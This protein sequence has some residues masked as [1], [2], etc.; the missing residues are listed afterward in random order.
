MDPEQVEVLRRGEELLARA[1]AVART[2][3]RRAWNL[4]QK[5]RPAARHSRDGTAGTAAAECSPVRP[6]DTPLARG[7]GGAGG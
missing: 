7:D 6:A 5:Y 2:I 4:M 3:E 1:R